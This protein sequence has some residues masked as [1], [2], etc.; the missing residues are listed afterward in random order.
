MA[1]T[2]VFSV[3]KNATTEL[4]TLP[5]GQKLAIIDDFLADPAAVRDYAVQR[6]SLFQMPP[7]SYP[8][9]VMDV[10]DDAMQD[11]YRFIRASLAR[12][13]DFLRGGARFSSVFS[14]T[15]LQPHELGNLQR[16]CH[17][18]PPAGPDR[19]NFA[20]VLYLFGNS[21]LGGT[22]FYRWKEKDAI[23]EATALEM[24][25]PDAAL[26]YLTARFQT[27]DRKPCYMTDSNEI[28]ERVESVGARNNRLVFYSGDVPHSAQIAA[29]DLLSSDLT[30]G[31][32]TLNCFASVRPR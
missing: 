19:R 6:Q 32:L 14:M 20:F 24:S 31:R 7:K 16:L 8:G 10:S 4:R 18:D 15:T 23:I 9:V 21:E 27:F 2:S 17:T 28:A 13:F 30:T 5:C 29:P 12:Q 1:S 26:E 25:N 22:G 11:I 3:N